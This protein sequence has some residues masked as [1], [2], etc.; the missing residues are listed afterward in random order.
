M[1][2][3]SHLFDANKSQTGE[4]CQDQSATWLTRGPAAQNRQ[5]SKIGVFPHSLRVR[6]IQSSGW[7]SKAA[8]RELRAVVG[9]PESI[10]QK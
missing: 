3:A 2:L 10:R 7:F 9:R 6:L 8:E 1:P 4:H 5:D